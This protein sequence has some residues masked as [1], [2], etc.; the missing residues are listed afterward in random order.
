MSAML[1]TN[2]LN[3]H[4]YPYCHTFCRRNATSPRGSARRPR[5]CLRPV[6]LE[7]YHC[8]ARARVPNLYWPSAGKAKNLNSKATNTNILHVQDPPHK[9]TAF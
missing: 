3:T 4:S 9:Q 8:A 1:L 6:H 7:M 2:E 5:G